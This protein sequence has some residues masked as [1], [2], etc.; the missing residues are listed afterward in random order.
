MIVCIWCRNR[1]RRASIINNLFALFGINRSS[2]GFCFVRRPNWLETSDRWM[3]AI[4][5][6]A[7]CRRLTTAEPYAH[8]PTATCRFGLYYRRTLERRISFV[9]D[10]NRF[11]RRAMMNSIQLRASQSR[12][13]INVLI[14][15]CQLAHAS[16]FIPWRMRPSARSRTKR[17]ISVTRCGRHRARASSIE[18]FRK[19][20]DAVVGVHV[21]SLLIYRIHLVN[22]LRKCWCDGK[23]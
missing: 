21:C 2:S 8:I 7:G 23:K 6:A 22:P 11:S 18:W 12:D 16:G 5:S 1:N 15:W 14:W 20:F 13:D 3:W 19:Y 17:A 10:V 9:S 4:V